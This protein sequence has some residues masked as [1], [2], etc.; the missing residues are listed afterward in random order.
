[1]KT[2]NEIYVNYQTPN[3]H[4]DKGTAHSYIDEYEILLAPYRNKSTIMEIGLYHG[5]SLKMWEEYFIDST[6]VGV[7]IN[8]DAIKHVIDEGTHNIIITD[9]TKEE[10]LPMINDYTFDII[11]DDGSHTIEDQISS[12]NLLKGKMKSGGL[13]IIE[14]IQD[15]DQHKDLLLSLHEN[16]QI[17]DNRHIKNNYDDILVIYK[18]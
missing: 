14:D 12:F 16:T 3:F 8:L 4:G 5:V 2:L 1:M 10:F 6:I 11:I 13:Y 17:I 15:I 7:D 18:F 9:A